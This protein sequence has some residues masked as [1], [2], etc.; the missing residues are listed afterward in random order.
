[1]NV[2][3]GCEYSQTVM[4]A[5]RKLGHNAWS[6]DT[7][8]TEGHYPEFH[9]EGDILEFLKKSKIKWDLGIFHPPCTYLSLS[10]VS[11]LHHDGSKFKKKGKGVK[12]GIE[13][14]LALYEGAMFF[15]SLQELDIP[16]IC[17][18][19]PIPNPYARGYI[20]M[21]TQLIQPYHFGHMESKA[22]CLWLKGL[23]K[24][25]ESRNVYAE[26]MLIPKKDRQK[27][28]Y[29]SPGKDRSKIRSKT[30]SGIANALAAQYGRIL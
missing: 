5:F 26:M 3:V 19:N 7:L 4:S 30:Y 1:M 15:R 16:K 20:G 27:C 24:L 6:C 2:I 8:P 12:Y 29:A 11:A 13:R 23:P 9:H 28:F 10:S 21:Y 14:W 17:I 25:R 22:T 18:E